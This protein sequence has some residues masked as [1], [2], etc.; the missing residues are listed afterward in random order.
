MPPKQKQSS[1]EKTQCIICRSQGSA[2]VGESLG[3]PVFQKTAGPLGTQNL[4]LEDR[5]VFSDGSGF[6]LL[7]MR[8]FC[9]LS[10]TALL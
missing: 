2:V 5:G 1:S 8:S 6:P 7:Q 3:A 10:L 9:S 4:N